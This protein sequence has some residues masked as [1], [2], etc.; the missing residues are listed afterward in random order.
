MADG[1]ETEAKHNW[2]QQLAT[3]ARVSALPLPAG[4]ERAKPLYTNNTIRLTLGNG[5]GR[6]TEFLVFL[7][8]TTTNR[9][10]QLGCTANQI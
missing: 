4:A 6:S 3:R 5:K 8:Y 7:L 2:Q 9:L 10:F 1:P